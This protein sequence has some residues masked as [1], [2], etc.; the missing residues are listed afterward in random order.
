MYNL[1]SHLHVHVQQKSYMYTY[2]IQNVRN[3]IN[4][5]KAH[6]CVLLFSFLL[7]GNQQHVNVLMMIQTVKQDFLFPV[8][9]DFLNISAAVI[10]FSAFSR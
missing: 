4:M 3:S 10:N 5:A 6:T 8:Q 1:Y 2:N 7:S 9:R